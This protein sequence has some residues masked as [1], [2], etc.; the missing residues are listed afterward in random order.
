MS[1]MEEEKADEGKKKALIVRYYC[2]VLYC[3]APFDFET[4]DNT[5]LYDDDTTLLV[6]SM[7]FH[8]EC[9]QYSHCTIDE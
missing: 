8:Q 3:T 9:R 1:R 4:F 5:I 6:Y 7:D 2:T